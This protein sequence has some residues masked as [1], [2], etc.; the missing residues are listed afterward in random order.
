MNP[1][2]N[3]KRKT[4]KEC[5]GYRTLF[6]NEDDSIEKISQA[7][8][9]KLLKGEYAIPKYADK[10]VRTVQALVETFGNKVTSIT[11]LWYDKITFNSEGKIDKDERMQHLSLAVNSAFVSISAEEKENLIIIDATQFF[12]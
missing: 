8:M 3:S 5:T 7:K 1:E 4:P 12:Y 11:H 9:N 6:I 10:K 2:D